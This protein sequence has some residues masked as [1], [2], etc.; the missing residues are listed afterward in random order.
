VDAQKIDEFMH[1]IFPNDKDYQMIKKSIGRIYKRI[2]E[3]Y[4][5]V[6][7]EGLKVSNKTIKF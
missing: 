3:N 2:S 1:R 4:E 7:I 6:D 5:D